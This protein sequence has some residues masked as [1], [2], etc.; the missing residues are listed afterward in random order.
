MALAR[1]FIKAGR[2]RSRSHARRWRRSSSWRPRAMPQQQRADGWQI[3][4][5]TSFVLEAATGRPDGRAILVQGWTRLRPGECRVAVGAPLARGT[6]YLYA[7]T[8]PAHRGGRRQWGGRRQSLRRSFALVHDRE[9][10]AM[11]GD[12]AGGAPLPP[13]A[14]QQARQLAHLVRRSAALHADARAPG[15]HC[16][17]CSIDAGYEIRQGRGGVDPRRI[18]AAIAQFRSAARLAAERQRRT[19]DRRARNRGAPPRRTKS[20]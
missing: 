20:G 16:S 10:A 12:G 6:H 11:P 4:N 15:R 2:A 1:S 19:D 5:E 3:C 14:D 18:A 17:A 7:R 13:R 8:S 9:P